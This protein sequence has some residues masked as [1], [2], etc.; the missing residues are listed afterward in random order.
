VHFPSL[1]LLGLYPNL[2]SLLLQAALVVVIACG[3]AYAH[4]AA[5]RAS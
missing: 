4:R 3:F 5:E 1:P 2:Q